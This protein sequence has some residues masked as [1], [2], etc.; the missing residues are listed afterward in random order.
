MYDGLTWVDSYSTLNI[1]QG[2][3]G[4]NGTVG[5]VD[6]EDAKEDDENYLQD[7]QDRHMSCS[8]PH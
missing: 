5:V 2:N 6:H 4:P 8:S 3:V 7:D 1:F